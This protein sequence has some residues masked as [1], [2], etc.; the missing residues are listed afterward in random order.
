MRHVAV[1]EIALDRS[2]VRALIGESQ[3]AGMAQHVGMHGYRE[4]AFSPYLRSSRLMVERCRGLRRS[5]RK[6]D[7][8]GAFSRAHSTSQALSE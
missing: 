5:L 6:N 8:P 3:A 4:L 7:R 1:P 2:S